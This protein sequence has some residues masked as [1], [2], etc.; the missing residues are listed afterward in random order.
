M[1]VEIHIPSLSKELNDSLKSD[2]TLSS[3]DAVVN[4]I[5]EMMTVTQQIRLSASD[6]QWP[7]LLQRWNEFNVNY[8]GINRTLFPGDN[9]L[10]DTSANRLSPEAAHHWARLNVDLLKLS[11]EARF[12]DAL[13]I[14]LYDTQE[15]TFPESLLKS[16]IFTRVFDDIYVNII[17]SSSMEYQ[18]TT[19]GTVRLV[20]ETNYPQETE[21]I[22]R[23]ETNDIRFLNL[24]I[25]IPSWAVNPIV[26]YGNVKYVAHPG[27]YCQ[28]S[29]KWR[30]GDEI[31]V[32]LRN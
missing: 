4:E 11:A 10:A 24:Y 17:G 20:Q 30:S 18:H 7:D 32:A 28:I 16:V 3:Q 2:D 13:E 23:C 9:S 27:E 22:L 15:F 25:R 26:S 19:G 6:K 21:M 14:L 29:R 8:F 5:D 1:Q 12:G 31:R